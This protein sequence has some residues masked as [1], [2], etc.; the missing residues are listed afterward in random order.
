M[1][2]P[3]CTV[4]NGYGP[5][6]NTT[7][8]CCHVMRRGDPVPESVPIGKPVSNTRVYILDESLRPVP[9]RTPG[10]LYAGGDGVA[11]GYLKDPIRNG[12]E[13]S[14]PIR[15]LTKRARACT[16]QAIWLGG[17]KTAWSSFLGESTT[18]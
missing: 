4:I 7:F 5:T 2:F 18:R 15:F 3:E 16:E 17:A 13:S 12:G 10:E 11:R 1:N 14:C 6:E 8:T 9:P